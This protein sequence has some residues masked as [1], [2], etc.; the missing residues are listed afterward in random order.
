M[1]QCGSSGAVA[2]F[3]TL[4]LSLPACDSEQ[5]THPTNLYFLP[6]GGNGK[7]GLNKIHI[8]LL[9][10]WCTVRLNHLLWMATTVSLGCQVPR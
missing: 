5:T 7:Q 4:V 1:L 9:A 10:I 2:S 8:G 6:T 3:Q